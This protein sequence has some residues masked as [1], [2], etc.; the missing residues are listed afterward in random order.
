M[1][2]ENYKQ[3]KDSLK[4]GDEYTTVMMS[5]DAYNGLDF[6]MDEL[7]YQSGIR[8]HNNDFEN[9]ETHKGIV[10]DISKLKR[11]LVNYEFDKNH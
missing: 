9:D 5:M 10:K 4:H 6:E 8:Q 7:I 1:I 11:M 3:F 2:T